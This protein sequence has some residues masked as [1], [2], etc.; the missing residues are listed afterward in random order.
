MLTSIAI[1][2][3]A[4]FE[5]HSTTICSSQQWYLQ[6]AAMLEKQTSEIEVF[7]TVRCAEN[8]A[9][10]SL[11]AATQRRGIYIRCYAILHAMTDWIVCAHSMHKAT[12][13]KI[14]MAVYHLSTTSVPG[15]Q[16]NSLA[17]VLDRFVS[18]EDIKMDH[19][20]QNRIL[21]AQP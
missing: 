2:T 1:L 13:E 11:V 7:G 18:F 14:D 17:R 4:F 15:D 21:I 20:C 16:S 12:L 19:I 10:P 3:N 5:K 9:N 6:L 8:L